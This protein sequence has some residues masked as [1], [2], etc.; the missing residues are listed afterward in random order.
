MLK[1][2]I[3]LGLFL[4]LLSNTT[5]V[6]A[7]PGNAELVLENIQIEPAYPQIGELTAITADVYN[8]GLVNT[9]SLSSI[10]TAAF[11]VDDKL[12][13]VDEIGNVEFGLSNKLKISSIP[14][15]FAEPGDHT[16]KIILDYH[17]TLDDQYDSPLDNTLEKLFSILPRTSPD[18]YLHAS[19]PYI[20]PGEH[21]PL[22]ITASVKDPI[23]DNPLGN[24]QIMIFFDGDEIPLTTSSSGSIS[25]SKVINSHK[26][27]NAEVYF[28]GDN[29]HLPSSS[30][31]LIP[32]IPN[33]LTS[34]LIIKIVDEYRQYN[35][36]DNLF[37]FVIFQDSYSNLFE[38]ISPTST[39]L[40]KNTFWVY[41]P[42]KH[43]YFAEVYLDGQFFIF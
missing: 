13:Y 6:D 15:W 4:I 2:F 14:I 36:Q 35:F 21:N 27:L 43:D 22:E 9:D 34:G 33:E 19:P 16:V 39:L 10:V 11:F 37:E 40:D 25:F 3:F 30:S 26:S 8:A 32:V 7:I 5:T 24:K 12:L 17:N 20:V 31:L 42:P 18:L 41:L 28:D 29:Q 1:L 23:S 38:K